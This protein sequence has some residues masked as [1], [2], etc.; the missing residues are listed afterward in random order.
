MKE[1]TDREL[2]DCIRQGH[3]PA[4]DTLYQR[5]SGPL[6]SFLSRMLK[7]EAAVEDLFHETFIRILEN[8]GRYDPKFSFSTWV[9]K[10]ASNL[11][12]TELYKRKRETIFNSMSADSSGGADEQDMMQNVISH[13]ADPLKALELND[14]RRFMHNLLESLPEKHRTSFLLKFYYDMTYKEIAYIEDCSE[15]TIKSRIHYGLE[16]LRQKLREEKRNVPNG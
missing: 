12:F 2:V 7:D 10:I 3:M 8:I 11:C 4:F 15:G 6:M 14:D 1:L 9:Y 5:Y 16:T 13:D